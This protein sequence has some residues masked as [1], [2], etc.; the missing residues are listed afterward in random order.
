MKRKLYTTPIACHKC[1]YIC[2]FNCD[3]VSCTLLLHL[4][5]LF[6]I[7]SFERRI[8]NNLPECI[9]CAL[10]TYDSKCTHHNEF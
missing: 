6:Y 8:F 9:Q 1:N 3:N 10:L 2:I 4:S 7:D 5:E